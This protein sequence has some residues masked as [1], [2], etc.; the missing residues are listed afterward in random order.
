MLYVGETYEII[1][2]SGAGSWRIPELEELRR[3]WFKK[4]G[5]SKFPLGRARWTAM[6]R[7]RRK[8]KC[9][10][11]LSPVDRLAAH[12]DEPIVAGAKK[13]VVDDGG[14]TG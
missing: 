11:L 13:V 1:I 12:E 3:Y 14:T 10:L 2:D 9:P 4:R 5:H 8:V 7:S 6:I